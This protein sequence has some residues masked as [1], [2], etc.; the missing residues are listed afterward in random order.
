MAPDA[1]VIPLGKAAQ[2]A[3]ALLIADGILDVGRCV[4]GFP[5]PSGQN[6]HRVKHYAA[7]RDDMAREVGRWAEAKAPA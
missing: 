2:T 3:A 4:I 6:G 5:H 7:E 1:L